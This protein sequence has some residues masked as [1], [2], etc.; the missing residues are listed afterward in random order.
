MTSKQVENILNAAT[1]VVSQQGIAKL[2]ID[3]VAKQAG[4]SKGGVLHHFRTKDSLVQ[5]MVQ[6]SADGWRNCY[7]QAYDETPEGPGRM[8]RALIQHCLSDA[9]TWTDELRESSSA[10]FAALA[11]Q[12][13]LIA[14]MREAYEELHTRL[15][16][17]GLPAGM[18]ETVLAAVDGMWLRWVL[19]LGEVDQE[20]V[21]RVRQALESM[22]DN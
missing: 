19:G 10:V 16:D 8:S 21:D 18:A 1:A 9:K 3:A 20:L 11:H 5:A 13:N 7:S 17:D 15:A 6:R 12:P 22:L 14:P 4:I 2:T